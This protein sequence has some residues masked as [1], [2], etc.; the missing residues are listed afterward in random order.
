MEPHRLL[1]LIDI[2]LGLWQSPSSFFTSD[3][4]RVATILVVSDV[5]RKFR[6]RG[7]WRYI[8]GFLSNQ[9][10]KN[11]EQISAHA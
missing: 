5:M 8:F 10:S 6:K 1:A 4:V 9:A 7:A 2:C 3:F 11:I